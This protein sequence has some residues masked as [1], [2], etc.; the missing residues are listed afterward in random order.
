[1][2]RG[3]SCV[4]RQGDGSPFGV[5]PGPRL[6]LRSTQHAP[7]STPSTEVELTNGERL[8]LE[9]HGRAASLTPLDVGM[10][11]QQILSAPRLHARRLGGGAL[12]INSAHIL[13]M[14]RFPGPPETPP[15][16]WPAEPLSG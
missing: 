9:V 2:L 3:A 7:R 5:R 6:P 8:F 1:V 14:A 4:L 10:L 16:A 15:N 12:L 13:C 11:L